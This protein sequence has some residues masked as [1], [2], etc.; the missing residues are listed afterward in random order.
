MVN[1][2]GI[3][4]YSTKVVQLFHGSYI[5]IYIM[6]H[7]YNSIPQT[8]Y[9]W[10]QKHTFV[11][12]IL[13]FLTSL[14]NFYCYRNIF[15]RIYTMRVRV[16]MQEFPFSSYFCVHSS[17]TW[18]Y[19][20]FFVSFNFDFLFYFCFILFWTA[21]TAHRTLYLNCF[22]DSQLLYVIVLWVLN[23]SFI[24][25]GSL[26]SRIIRFTNFMASKWSIS[27]WTIE[28]TTLFLLLLSYLIFKSS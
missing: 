19:L 16:F 10:Y 1:I 15:R 3:F 25:F 12:S 11:F 18:I 7:P 23:C 17:N 4:K 6:E 21:Y 26:F 14:N 8:S 20:F 9:K 27:Y 22:E 28:K 24:W 13:V 2:S 5:Y